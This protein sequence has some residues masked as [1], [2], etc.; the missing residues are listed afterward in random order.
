MSDLLKTMEDIVDTHLTRIGGD[1]GFEIDL[2]FG[3]E[4]EK[5]IL[6]RVRK[7]YPLA[8]M[9][10][11]KHKA[12]DIFVPEKNMG[13]EIK[14]DR[15]AEKTGNVFIEIECNKTYSGIITTTAEWF[16]YQT[17]S[18]IFWIKT[19]ELRDYLIAEAKELPMFNNT[20]RGEMSS[21]RG[22]LVPVQDFRLLSFIVENTECLT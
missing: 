17:D 4:A 1:M 5:R 22:Y 21:V 14:C 12:Y 2:E 16:V 20:P 15:R 18:R 6:D 11:G 9:V 3:K 13:I 19:K 7:K 10:E 8:F